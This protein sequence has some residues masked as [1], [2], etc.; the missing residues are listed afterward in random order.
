MRS[1]NS[2]FGPFTRTDSGS[3]ATV[4]PAGTGMGCLPILDM[5]VPSPLYQT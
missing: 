1:I 5:S 2:P 3:I 4:T